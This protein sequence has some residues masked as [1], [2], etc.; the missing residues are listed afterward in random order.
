MINLFANPPLYPFLGEKFQHTK[1][2]AFLGKETSFPSPEKNVE[3]NLLNYY[4]LDA[5]SI[6]PVEAL[7][8]TDEDDFILDVCAAPGGKT[9][10]IAQH[11][12]LARKQKNSDASTVSLTCNEPSPDRNKRLYNVTKSYIGKG[13][14]VTVSRYD[15]TNINSF[16]GGSF[17][18]ILVDAPCSSDRHLI[19]K[20]EP[21]AK[22]CSKTVKK[23]RQLLLNALEWLRPGGRLVY[24]TCSLNPRENDEVV[25]YVLK[26]YKESVKVVRPNMPIGEKTNFG[27]LMLPDKCEGFGPLYFATIVK[28]E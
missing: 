28:D 13:L 11:V 18:K 1:I 12:Y 15:A 20:G 10:A 24:A 26:K 27:W 5:A 19:Q 25:G 6:L 3:S 23:Q 8:I 22:S 7:N 9:L 14:N 2:P 17:D 21:I 16:I 4:L